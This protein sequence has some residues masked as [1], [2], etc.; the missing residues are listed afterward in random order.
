MKLY[1][2]VY[3]TFK[4]GL[5]IRK[6]L[7]I[8]HLCHVTNVQTDILS[9]HYGASFCKPQTDGHFVRSLWGEFLWTPDWRTFRPFIMGWVSVN[10][11][12]TDIPSIHFGASFC[13]PQTD[14][15]SVC[16][17]WG[18]F[19]QYIRTRLMMYEVNPSF[20]HMLDP[21]LPDILNPSLPHM[22][23]PRGGHSCDKCYHACTLKYGKEYVFYA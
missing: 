4:W 16:S 14:R 17:L 23:N 18:D 10:P 7:I 8:K 12:L 6:Y 2:N 22:L 13:E 15:H 3:T 11:R 21:S 9:V 1:W 19:C 5:K 20:P